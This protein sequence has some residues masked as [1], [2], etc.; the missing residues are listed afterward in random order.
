MGSSP[1]SGTKIKYAPRRGVYFY[2]A[3]DERLEK[4]RVF[5][6]LFIFIFFGYTVHIK[7]IRRNL[8]GQ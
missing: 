7:I 4:W 1:I 2:F 3:F 6:F 8:Y 5:I